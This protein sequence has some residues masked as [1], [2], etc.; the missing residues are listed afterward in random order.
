MC[1]LEPLGEFQAS[2]SYA[3]ET[4]TNEQE[5]NASSPHLQFGEGN[6]NYVPKHV[7]AL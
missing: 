4:D 6:L 2:Y 7:F 3:E 1:F 5:E